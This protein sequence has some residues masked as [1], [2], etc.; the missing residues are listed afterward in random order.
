MTVRLLVT[1]VPGLGHLHPVLPLGLAAVRAGHEVRVATG[2]DQ[3]DW[4][5]RCGVQ[6]EA[7]GLTH[8]GLVQ[9]GASLGLTGPERPRQMFTT[10][11]VP[12]M[13]EDLLALVDRWS[14]DVVVHEE[15]EYAAPLVAALRGLP[16]VTHSW[17]APARSTAGRALLDEPLGAV[18]QRF[19]AAGP[20]RQTG[21]LYLDAC[22]PLLQIPSLDQVAAR[23]VPVH[24]QAFDGPAQPAPSW[25]AALP[26]PAV[27]VTLG[28]EPTFCR[29]DLLQRLVDAVAA[30]APGVVVSTG[31]HPPEVLAPHRA[32]VHVVQYLPQSLVL[33]AVD[34]VVG[35]GGAGTTV[36]ALLHGRPLLVVPG[37]APSQQA[38]AAQV[39]AAGVGLRLDW[40][41]ATPERLKN[42][43]TELLSRADLQSAAQA[44]RAVLGDLPTPDDVVRLLERE[45]RTPCTGPTPR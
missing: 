25:L 27:Y 40:D 33:P 35:H 34:A 1:S 4:V 2:A 7:A 8:A 32:G 41:D 30:V 22:P 10:I 3:L 21:Q 20:P 24:A 6:G 42:A 5:Q 37:T 17:P 12:P 11:A 15:G 45:A 16:C 19:G 44:A 36:G 38:C 28:T 31:P 13:A 23:I 14:P 26:H 39:R 18:W 9:Q 43:V 29:P